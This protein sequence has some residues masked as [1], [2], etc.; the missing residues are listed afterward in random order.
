MVCQEVS[1]PA[2]KA[3]QPRRPLLSAVPDGA[4]PDSSFTILEREDG[5]RAVILRYASKKD[6]L[7]TDQNLTERDEDEDTEIT[8]DECIRS[9]FLG[10]RRLMIVLAAE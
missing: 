9:E 6:Y 8:S 1:P 10:T 7:E 4:C 2:D 3:G 5:R